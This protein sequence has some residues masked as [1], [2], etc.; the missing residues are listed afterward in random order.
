MKN[1]ALNWKDA[2]V[3]WSWLLERQ[4]TDQGLERLNELSLIF[5]DDVNEKSTL[6][7]EIFE[8]TPN[9]ETIGIAS[10]RSLEAFPSQ[11]LEI[12]NRVPGNLK[13]LFLFA[14]FELHSIG[15]PGYLSQLQ[16]L[17]VYGCPRLTTLVVQ[18]C[19]NLK[20]LDIQECHELQFL[21]TSSVAKMLTHLEEMYIEDC[22]S[23][24]EIVRKEQDDETTTGEI[25]FERLESISLQSLS[26][27]EYFYSGNATLQLPSLIQV[28]IADCPKMRIF[29]QGLINAESFR[30]INRSHDDLVFHN[31]LNAAIELLFL[32]QVRT[33]ISIKF[34]FVLI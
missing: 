20:V 28:D 7:F 26:S 12:G 33:S 25:N 3:L 31:D 14:L 9:L 18:S 8:K 29:S 16:L 2:S 4:S 11:N 30:G 13:R 19:S 21:F 34:Y 15:R 22:E 6:P 10:F 17:H 23:M 27:L 1:L 5:D 24:K 32:Y